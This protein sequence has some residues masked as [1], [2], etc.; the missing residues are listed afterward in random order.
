MLVEQVTDTTLARQLR[1][2][3][4]D[5]LGLDQTFSTPGEAIQGAQ[6][7]GYS[8]TTDQ[9]DAPMSF[10]FATANIVSTA[11]DLQRF[12][13]ALVGGRL[14]E[15]DTLAEMQEFVN[16]KGRYKMPELEY[17]LGLMRN[18]LAVGPGPGGQPRPPEAGTVLGHI[19]GFG[20]F[21]SAV[22]T[23]PASGTTVALSVNQADADP[24]IL[25]TKA[26]D[27]ILTRQGQ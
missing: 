22:W 2:R 25:A 20:G 24:N 27:A 6:A 10:V 17:G 13:E 21:R 11:S 14:L 19:G 8:D 12:A 23:A 5:P 7:H 9:T 16:G 18:R 4:F 15:P 26:F 3:I 1:Q